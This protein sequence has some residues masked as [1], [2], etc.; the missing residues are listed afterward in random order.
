MSPAIKAIARHSWQRA[1]DPWHA[2]CASCGLE[3]RGRGRAARH[4]TRRIWIEEYSRD[5]ATWTEAR[6]PAPCTGAR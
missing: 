1:S 5:G 3:R 6:V 2:V 4:G